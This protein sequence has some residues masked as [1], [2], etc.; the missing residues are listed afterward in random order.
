MNANGEVSYTNSMNTW[1]NYHHVEIRIN[2]DCPGFRD[3]VR[4]RKRDN[5]YDSNT[6]GSAFLL[7]FEGVD[8]DVG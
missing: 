2:A 1:K 5:Y 6:V 4:V 3:K 7:Y 8:E